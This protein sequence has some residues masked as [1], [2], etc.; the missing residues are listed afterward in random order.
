MCKANQQ[1]GHGRQCSNRTSWK[2]AR[3]PIPRSWYMFKWCLFP[4]RMIR[5]TRGSARQCGGPC[6]MS[7]CW[8]ARAA[9]CQVC[10]VMYI[11]NPYHAGCRRQCPTVRGSVS[12][13]SVLADPRCR[14]ASAYDD[15]YSHCMGCGTAWRCVVRVMTQMGAVPHRSCCRAAVCHYACLCVIG[16]CRGKWWLLVAPYVSVLLA[17]CCLGAAV[18]KH[19]CM[20]VCCCG[21]GA[22][23]ACGLVISVCSLCCPCLFILCFDAGRLIFFAVGSKWT[24]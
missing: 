24:M 18:C 4:I 5:G 15:G 6:R 14:L 21:P 13:V 19:V 7:L 11:Q 16:L 2:Q 17:L 3:G 23:L 10:H 9:T 1:Q 20:S 8:R 22:L 12:Y